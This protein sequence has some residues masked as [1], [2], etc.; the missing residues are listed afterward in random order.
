VS[1]PIAANTEQRSFLNR[2]FLIVIALNIVDII[3][4]LYWYFLYGPHI[5]GNQIMLYMYHHIAPLAPIICKIIFVY[6]S[7]I[8]AQTDRQ[9][10]MKLTGNSGAN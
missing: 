9:F 2:I 1:D 6:L 10:R 8:P 7:R 5:E 3:I 4:T